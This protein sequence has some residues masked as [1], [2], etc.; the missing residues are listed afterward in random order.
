MINVNKRKSF[1]DTS[2]HISLSINVGFLGGLG[3]GVPIVFIMFGR[4][5]NTYLNVLLS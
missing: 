1:M 3:R 2:L 4:L 5:M